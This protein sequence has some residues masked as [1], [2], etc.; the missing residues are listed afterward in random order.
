MTRIPSI[1]ID[2][3]IE[4][5]EAL[6]LDAYGVL[7]HRD[8]PLPG[9]VELIDTLNRLGKPYFLLSNTAARLPEQA[10][11]R[12]R[13]FGLA[14]EAER[15]ITSGSLLAAYFADRGWV[16]KR[17]A[18]LGPEGS[19]T[20]VERAGGEIVPAHEDF[21]VLLIG[22]QVGFPFLETVDAALSRLIAKL[23]RDEPVALLL[24]NPDLIYP[25][26][27]GFGVTSGA[28]ALMIEAALKQRYPDRPD[29]GFTRL[30]KPE[31]AMFEEAARRSGTRELV[32][33]GDQI[34]T[35]ILGANRF[36]IASALVAGGVAGSGFR[37][38][39]SGARPTYLLES[40]VPHR[41]LTL[42][43]RTDTPT[44]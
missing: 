21:E 38:S 13:G 27:S 6:L 15:I 19:L 24:P 8:G 44:G 33:I 40:I 28:V 29:I 4:R 23:D 43:P 32:M 34:E 30:G 14:L 20:Y 17:C 7:V 2:S 25:K 35:D 31:P 36:G 26:A 5:H 11:E 3:L 42:R 39:P 10:A 37:A 16:G 9:A 41:R 22:D 18:V 1:D 12:Y